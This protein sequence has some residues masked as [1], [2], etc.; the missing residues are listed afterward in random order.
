MTIVITNDD[1]IDA[2]GIWALRKALGDR[3]IVIAPLEHQSGCSHQLTVGRSIRVEQRSPHAY[4][5]DGTPADCTRLALK[6]LYPQAQWILSGINA[7]ANLGTDTYSSGTVAAVREGAFLRVPGIAISHYIHNRRPIDW[8][9]A[10]RLTAKVLEKLMGQPS[11]PGLFWNV[12]LP[13]PDTVEQEPELVF[14][15]MCTQPMPS[16]YVMDEGGYRY[17]GRFGDR[18]RDP[19]ADV[20]ICF[21]GHIAITPIR[22]WGA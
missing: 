14:C 22:V 5:V 4:A 13:H 21:S 3:G 20:D 19:G 11:E 18:Q 7:G 9:Q 2:P 10:T 16:E 15:D 6:H 8:E 12:N 1:G 17:A